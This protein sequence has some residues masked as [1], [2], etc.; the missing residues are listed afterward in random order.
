M[1]VKRWA[2][3]AALGA[4]MVL[5][6]CKQDKVE[7]KYHPAKLEESGQTGI[8]KIRL[9]AKAAERIGVQTGPVMEE[10]VG[11]AKRLVIP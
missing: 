2:T 11:A 9:D 5:A 6:G 4:V 3:V 8:M 7:E 10:A 1:Q